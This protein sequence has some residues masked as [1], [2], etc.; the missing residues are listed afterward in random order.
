MGILA[1]IQDLEEELKR[2]GVDVDPTKMKE[3]SLIKCG[4]MDIC[5]VVKR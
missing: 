1:L 4:G 2:E 5:M 3:G